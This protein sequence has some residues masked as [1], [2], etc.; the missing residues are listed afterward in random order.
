[1]PFAE[2]QPGNAGLALPT[3]ALQSAEAASSLMERAQRRKM[4]ETDFEM[5]QQKHAADLATTDLTQQKMRAEL[6]MQEMKFRETE[7]TVREAADV[8]SEYNRVAPNIDEALRVIQGTTDPFEQRRLLTQLETQAARFAKDPQVMEILGKQMSSTQALINANENSK[9]QDYIST[10]QYATNR[11]EAQMMFPGQ[12]LRTITRPGPVPG[13]PPS[14]FFVPTGKADPQMEAQAMSLLN[15]ARVSGDVSK[16][17]AILQDPAVQSVLRV[18]GS[19]FSAEY[20]KAVQTMTEFARK[21]EADKRAADDQRMQQQKFEQENTALTVPGFAGKARSA[22]VAAKIA[23]ESAASETS[24]GLI[25]ELEDIAKEIEEDPKKIAS[26]E[27]AGRAEV[28]AKLIQ[29]TN[30]ISIVGPGA[31]TPAEWAMLEKFAADPTD[32]KTLVPFFRARAKAGYRASSEALFNKTATMARQNGLEVDPRYWSRDSVRGR[33]ISPSGPS[34]PSDTVSYQGGSFK[35]LKADPSA[36]GMILV[37]DPKTKKVFRIP[38]ERTKPKP[39][40][41]QPRS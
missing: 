18:P 28:L 24:M 3:F 12:A 23:E 27:L 41:A 32:A 8:R 13:A 14:M 10:N 17:E 15:V 35:V 34:T 25:Y 31:V 9:L 22:I 21:R 39:A 38:D 2:F 37:Q 30:R 1:M 5:R 29:S 6:S 7:R 19:T 16:V 26:P 20:Q 4:A 40:E 11:A 36:P 33:R